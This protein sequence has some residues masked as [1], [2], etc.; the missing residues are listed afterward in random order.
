[1]ESP[2]ESKARAGPQIILAMALSSAVNTCCSR[3]CAGIAL[4]SVSAAS[5]MQSS[6]L[7][8]FCCAK[9]V[10]RSSSRR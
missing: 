5:S 9:Q 6:P 4:S 10:L 1:M 7:M 8:R 2:Q 3:T